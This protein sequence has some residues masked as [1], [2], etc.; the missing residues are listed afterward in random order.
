MATDLE[1]L[2]VCPQTGCSYNT[3]GLCMEN[4]GSDCQFL[5]SVLKDE[6]L[7]ETEVDSRQDI[8]L[9]QLASNQEI[10][11]I[12]IAR[13]TNRFPCNLIVLIGEPECGK[14]TLYAALFDKFNKGGCSGYYFSGTSTSI[15]FERRCHHARVISQNNQPKTERTYSHEFAYLHLSVRKMSLSV[16]SQHLLFADVNGEKYQAAR[17]DD[18]E[19]QSL[20]LLKSSD[21]IFFIA[22]GELLMNG[23]K[24]H[25]IKAD[26][27][28]LIG[29]AIQNQMISTEK[30][31]NLLI[32]KWDKINESKKEDEVNK[33]LV[34]AIESKF[35]GY[36][37]KTIHI[38]SRSQNPEVIAGTGIEDFFELCLS[39]P[40]AVEYDYED[41]I[42]TLPKMRQ[43]Q[44]FKYQD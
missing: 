37:K 39:T 14:S 38:A 16:P 35:P 24:K 34:E 30:G 20:T 21:H 22:D 25:S 3:N 27:L 4:N 17:N 41:M 40:E 19:M 43:F 32:T 10:E 6:L 33:F 42:E 23:G 13:I 11:E 44:K 18:E 12:N 8:E 1:T 29:R 31:V 7:V 15:A 36:L 26:V 9:F 28:K 2:K 5:Q